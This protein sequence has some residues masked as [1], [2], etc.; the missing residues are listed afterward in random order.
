MVGLCKEERKESSHKRGMAQSG[1]APASGAGGR[2]FKSRY[3]EILIRIN[4]LGIES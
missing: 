1:S 4:G 2:E 3:P